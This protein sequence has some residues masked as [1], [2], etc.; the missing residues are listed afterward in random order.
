MNNR[1]SYM[2]NILNKQPKA[3][4]FHYV[5][6]SKEEERSDLKA[7]TYWACVDN[8]SA[9]YPITICKING[10]NSHFKGVD[11][12]KMKQ[13]GKTSQKENKL[14]LGVGGVKILGKN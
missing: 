1:H 8:G 5:L 6:R 12:I 13:Q 14:L 9:A 2:I 3:F 10:C 11:M 4:E 7:Y